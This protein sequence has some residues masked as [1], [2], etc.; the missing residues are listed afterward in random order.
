[1]KQKESIDYAQAT[2]KYEQEAKLNNTFRNRMWLLFEVPTSS[3]NATRL[4]VVKMFIIA[5]SLLL[6]IVQSMS[7][8]ND[9][10]QDSRLC[11]QVINFYCEK[12]GSDTFRK[13]NP[14]CFAHEAKLLNSN[15]TLAYPGCRSLTPS[16][17][18]SCG[19]PNADLVSFVS[20]L[21]DQMNTTF[22]Q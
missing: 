3:V 16:T 6:L 21:M 19:F 20:Q 17:F 8:F 7:M 1:M 15:G 11:R 5:C 12:L 9:Y 10:G 18:D 14:A 4:N 13:A 22:R 2:F